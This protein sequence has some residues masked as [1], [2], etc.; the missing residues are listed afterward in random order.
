MPAGSSSLAT[1]SRAM[2]RQRQDHE[3]GVASQSSRFSALLPVCRV[4]EVR[5]PTFTPRMTIRSER[6]PTV[7]IISGAKTSASPIRPNITR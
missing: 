2:Q 5:F 4:L 7:E 3:S 6:E 1:V